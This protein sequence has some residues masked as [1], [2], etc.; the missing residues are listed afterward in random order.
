MKTMQEFI[1]YKIE[2]LDD[3]YPNAIPVFGGALWVY[4][5]DDFDSRRF[6]AGL[7]HVS[8]N[9]EFFK[10]HEG[11][12]GAMRRYCNIC[13]M[14]PVAVESVIGMTFEELCKKG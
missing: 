7:D 3:K 6:V 5:D 14:D 8:E 9:A 1:R 2:R 4:H 13:M 12:A 11:V 10:W